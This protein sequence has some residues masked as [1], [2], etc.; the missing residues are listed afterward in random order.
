MSAMEEQLL[1]LPDDYLKR[2]GREYGKAI[3]KVEAETALWYKRF[4]TNNKISLA[5]AKRYL[6]AGELEELKWMVDD[7]IEYATRNEL[8]PQ[9]IKELENAS[10]KIHISRL[11][12]LKLELKQQAKALGQKQKQGFT[13]TLTQ[14]YHDGY[15]RTG[16]EVQKAFGVGFEFGGVDE[17][18]IEKVLSSPWTSDG[19]TFSDRIWKQQEEL[20]KELET[21]LIQMILRGEG[22]DGT[23]EALAKRFGVAKH[24]AATLVYT[25]AAAFAESA[26]TD[27]YNELD[28]EKCCIDGTLDASTCETCGALD[29]T[30]L[31]MSDC[32]TG[33]TTP[34]FHPRC[35][36]TTVPHYDDWEEFGITPER[37]SRDVESGET[38]EVPADMTYQQWKAAQDEKYGAGTVDKKRKMRYNEKADRE[39]YNAYVSRLGDE[40]P[41][42]FEKFQNIKYD[43]REVFEELCEL[44]R[45]KGK[46]PE[47]TLSDYK[48]YKSI[49]A[50]DVTGS[51][52]VPP[53]PIDISKLAFK[54]EHAKRHGCTFE[55][56]VEY[57]K[58]AK[59][60]VTRKRWDGLHTNYFSFDGASYVA[61]DSCK[62]NTAFSSESF[63]A[64]TRS[65]MEVFR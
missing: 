23:A 5:E 37:F 9:W 61:D 59:F 10:A 12:A 28:L 20:I 43:N 29:G 49:I 26:R 35:R 24:R 34:P 65:I 30:V 27:A 33:V 8:D 32:R 4:A 47:A 14:V 13:E 31:K 22:P 63:D 52:R 16:Y 45:Y 58:N 41:K 19:T 11:D 15:F 55:E 25:E 2:L 38:F 44:Y 39:Q 46:V 51:V 17:K 6:T 54:D 53:A 36:C 3:K 7:Y 40:A 60:S 1:H 21:S 18:R 50:L 56:A 42:T 62:I 64:K 48:L 57:I